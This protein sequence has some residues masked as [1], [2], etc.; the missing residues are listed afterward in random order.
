M[1]KPWYKV[2]YTVYTHWPAINHNEIKMPEHI[3]WNIEETYFEGIRKATKFLKE[4]KDG[5]LSIIY[6]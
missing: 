2:E 1:T 4:H 5:K 6:R 3:T